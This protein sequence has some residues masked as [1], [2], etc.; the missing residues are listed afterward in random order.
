ML[1]PHEIILSNEIIPSNE[2]INS[3]SRGDGIVE[4]KV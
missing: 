4:E 1:A 2:M 3:I